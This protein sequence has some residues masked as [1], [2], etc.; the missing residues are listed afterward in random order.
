MINL[1]QETLLAKQAFEC[2]AKLHGVMVKH[3]H[4]DSGLFIDHPFKDHYEQNNQ[5][6]SHSAVNANI[7]NAVT[8]KRIRDL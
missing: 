1:G 4:A 2:Y 7:Q 6:L 3:Y 8:E 5:S